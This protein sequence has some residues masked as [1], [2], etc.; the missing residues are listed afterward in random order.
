MDIDYLPMRNLD[1]YIACALIEL[2]SGLIMSM[3]TKQPFDVEKASLYNCEVLK[4][5]QR[6]VA[7]LALNDTIEDILI[8]LGK[9]YHLIRSA[10]DPRYFFYLVLDKKSGNLGMGRMALRS[11]SDRLWFF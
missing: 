2:D 1:G 5:K 8:T 6:A 11:L 9:Q 10:K 3:D 4:A 7:A